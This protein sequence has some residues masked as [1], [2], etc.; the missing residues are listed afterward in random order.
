VVH[1][2]SDAVRGLDRNPFT[3]GDL[4]GKEALDQLVELL[5][6]VDQG[7]GNVEF[8]H[9]GALLQDLSPYSVVDEVATM[10]DPTYTRIMTTEPRTPADLI[11]ALGPPPK[12]LPP[13]VRIADDAG[14]STPDFHRFLTT[15]YEWQKRLAAI[16]GGIP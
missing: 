15:Q 12:P 6:D 10:K 9:R 11:L 2:L 4:L 5:L 13:Q 14:R 1:D 16:V 3:R 7:L 8:S